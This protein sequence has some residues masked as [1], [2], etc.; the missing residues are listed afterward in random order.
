MRDYV[1]PYAI[2]RLCLSMRN[3]RD[4]YPLKDYHRVATDGQTDIKE[5]LH[6]VNLRLKC[7]KMQTI[8]INTGIK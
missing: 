1:E 6:H 5:A 7:G 4:Y 3:V 8:V 2:N